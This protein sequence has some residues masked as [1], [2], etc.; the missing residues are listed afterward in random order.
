MDDS[1]TVALS[2][3]AVPWMRQIP[4]PGVPCQSGR[5]VGDFLSLAVNITTYISLGRGL[6][7]LPDTFKFVYFLNLTSFLYFLSLKEPPFFL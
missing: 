5:P 4:I 6:M 1:K 2:K 7:T 3:K